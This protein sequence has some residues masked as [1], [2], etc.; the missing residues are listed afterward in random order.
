[1]HNNLTTSGTVVAVVF[2]T[3]VATF[4]ITIL[5]CACKDSRAASRKKKAYDA[6]MEANAKIPLVTVDMEA[7]NGMP[8][9]LSVAK[10]KSRS[11]LSNIPL[12]SRY[13][14]GNED[15]SNLLGNSGQASPH[16]SLRSMTGGSPNYSPE[17][18]RHSSPSR[19]EEGH[20]HESRR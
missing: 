5:S 11:P 2:G 6:A 12:Q 13:L 14:D 9:S 8:R 15:T 19:S 1:M 16:P 17:G 20:Y 7:R 10:N 3:A 18:S 4:F